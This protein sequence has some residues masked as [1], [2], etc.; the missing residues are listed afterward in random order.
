MITQDEAIELIQKK[1]LNDLT[2]FKSRAG[3]DF[4]ASLQLMD[5]GKV[6]FKPR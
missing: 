1:E 3:S 4:K 5:D 2:G 6:Q